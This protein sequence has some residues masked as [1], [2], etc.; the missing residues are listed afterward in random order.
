M[1]PLIL[2]VHVLEF[3]NDVYKDQPFSWV[4]ARYN[5][6]VLKFSVDV[7]SGLDLSDKIDEDVDLRFDVVSGQHL[8]AVLKV[9]GVE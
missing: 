5:G 4:L 6:K 1:N 7:K 2:N 3:K 9:V 8:K